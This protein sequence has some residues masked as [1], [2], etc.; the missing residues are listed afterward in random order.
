MRLIHAVFDALRTLDRPCTR[1]EIQQHCRIDRDAA[2]KG[3][4]AL[5]RRGGLQI[6]ERAG[7]VTYALRPGAPRPLELRGRYARSLA[8][9]HLM[10]QLVGAQRARFSVAMPASH[11][12][13]PGV[14]RPLKQGLRCAAREVPRL[15]LLELLLKR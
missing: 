11:A 9:R 12:A 1:A 8:H 13:E 5:R 7:C 14:L 6:A 3:L 2:R 10:A 4:D 15:T